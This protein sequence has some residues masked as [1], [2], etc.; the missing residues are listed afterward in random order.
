MRPAISRIC[1]R[2]GRPHKGI[3]QS[4][5]FPPAPAPPPVPPPGPSSAAW[6]AAT[7]THGAGRADEASRCTCGRRTPPPRS[8][9]RRRT[10]GS[11]GRNRHGSRASCPSA[12]STGRRLH[13]P[14]EDRLGSIRSFA[15]LDDL[16]LGPVGSKSRSSA[17]PARARSRCSRRRLT[18]HPGRGDPRPAGR[19]GGTGPDWCHGTRPRG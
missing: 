16:G 11:R 17:G 3:A 18:L 19:R 7:P 8:P 5:S 1:V 9:C 4:S 10:P 13:G 2:S 12:P 6:S 14:P 15:Q